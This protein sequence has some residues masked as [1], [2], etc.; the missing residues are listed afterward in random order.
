[1]PERLLVVEDSKAIAKV[2]EQLGKA[3]G[4]EVTV[5][6][7]LADVEAILQGNKKFFAATIDYNLPDAP[8]GEAISCVLSH[9]IQSVV[10]TGRMDEETRQ[11]ILAQPVIDYIPKENSQAFMYLKR[12]LHGQ[13]LNRGSGILVVDD[14]VSARNHVVELLKRR[15]YSVFVASD[16]QKALEVIANHPEIKMVI[17]DLEMPVMDGITLTNEIRKKHSRDRIAI[18]GI[19]GANNGVHSARFIKNGADDFLRKPFCPEEF[20]C[21]VTQNIENLH[22]IEQIQRAAN[23]D[24][25]TDLPNRRAFIQSAQRKLPEM[26]E[27]NIPYCMAMIDID[28]FKKINDTYG[29]EAGDN[30]LKVVALYMRKHLS[31][32]LLARLGGEEFSILMPGL[33]EDQLY[34]RLDDL[35][36]ELSVSQIPYEGQQITMSVSIGVVFNSNASLAAQMNEADQALYYAKENGRNQVSI[37]GQNHD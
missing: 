37:A 32:A 26:I 14:S 23:T 22:N 20:Y 27:K 6:Y 5:A 2:I 28:F 31:G 36:R 9:G 17:T 11:K 34:G 29:H 10:M 7:T 33:D 13:L 30:V 24:Y 19:S 18:I 8:D 25:L 1:M 3:L 12:I 15:N 16:G 4:F 35:R 21:R